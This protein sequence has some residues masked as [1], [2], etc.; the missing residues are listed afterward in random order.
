MNKNRKVRYAVVGLGYIAQVAVLPSF[1]HARGAELKALVSGDPRKLK[2]LGRRYK[3]PHLYSYE[4]YEEC[5]RSG[6][7]D[8]VYLALP[9]HLHREYSVRASQEGIHVLCE[10]PMAVTSEECEAMI[11]AAR[12]SGTKL[13]VAYRLHF[14]QAN[15]E[16]AELA[17]RR[18]LGEP[19]IFSSV[20]S[21]PIKARN[22]RVLP[23]SEGGGPMYDIGI[24]CLNAARSIFGAEPTE[25]IATAAR[26]KDPRYS[27]IEEGMSVTLRFPDDRLAS[28]V[29]SYGTASEGFYDLLC[30]KG[31]A[32][33]EEAYEYVGPKKLTL[34]KGDGKPKEKTFKPRDQFAPELEYFADCIRRGR[35]PEPNG[36]EGL[37]DIRC[38][39]AIHKSAE[40]G[41]A[42]AI[43]PVPK[44]ERPGLKMEKQKPPVKEPELVKA[45]S[46]HEEKE[47]AA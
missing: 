30:K 40:T 2:E 22:I 3:V 10:K 12:R 20:F 28:F 45:E 31:S 37:A 1:K 33:L 29:C 36:L 25:A 44:Q 17:R 41:R 42:V 9:N 35:E 38:I 16:V 7:I 32:C 24:Y 8:A 13:M 47:E 27:G 23:R 14:E 11:Q 18:K 21:F 6:E 4:E 43:E 46:P 39:E 34:T 15:L 5:L 19:R 26:G